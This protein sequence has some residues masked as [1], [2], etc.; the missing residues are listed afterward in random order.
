[1]AGSVL[2]NDVPVLKAG[3]LVSDDA[4]IRIRGQDSQSGPVWVSRAG[5]KLAEALKAFHILAKDRICLDIG[6]STGGFTEV[7]LHAGARH[8]FAVDVGINQLDWKIRQRPEVTVLEKTN[9][10]YLTYEEIG[11]KVD[12]IVMDVS[13][14]SILKIIPALLPLAHSETD[15]VTLIKPQFE[16]GPDKVGK[17]GI[18][19][20]ET[21]RIAVVQEVSQACENLGLRQL[22]LIESSVVG[23]QGNQEYLAHWQLR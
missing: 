22:G 1:M 21:D 16:A 11:Q 15:W 13:F 14:I 12:I 19:R 3:T 4:E 10:R 8:V 6:A 2:V 5:G 17:G 18:L 7:L 20:S 9:A 23:R